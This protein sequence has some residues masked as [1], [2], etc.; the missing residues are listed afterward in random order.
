MLSSHNNYQVEPE[1]LVRLFQHMD[2]G[3]LQETDGGY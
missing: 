2:Q 1:P 3:V